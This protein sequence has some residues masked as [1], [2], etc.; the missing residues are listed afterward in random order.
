MPLNKDN[1]H[2]GLS[3]ASYLP[4]AALQQNLAEL[5]SPRSTTDA[6]EIT[7]ARKPDAF[8]FEPY[9]DAD[10]VS[11]FIGY[12][13]R[14]VLRWTRERKLPGYPPPGGKKHRNDWRYK[15]SEVDA[16]MCSTVHSE[17]R[18]CRPHGERIQ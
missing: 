5:S 15:L 14:T 1:N 17:R 2:A 12:D 4:P 7:T 16:A 8:S 6:R 18:P 13:R 9:V 11:G 10:V 3:G